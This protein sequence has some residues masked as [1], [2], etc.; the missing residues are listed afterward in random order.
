[1]PATEP[2]R[3]APPQPL[4][5]ADSAPFWAALAE[6][7]IRL[8]FSPQAGRWQFPPLERCRFTGGPLEWRD[9]DRSGTVHSFIVQHRPVAPGFADEMP[10]AILLVEPDDAPGVRLPT[11]LIDADP[12]RATVGMQV[13]LEVVAHPGG[14]FHVIVARMDLL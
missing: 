6:G 3:A 2:V 14:D 10:Y 4:P 8:Q 5:D 9:I 12:E 13:A 11:R 1:M 7:V